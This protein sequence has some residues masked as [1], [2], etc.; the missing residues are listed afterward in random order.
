MHSRRPAVLVLG[1]FCAALTLGSQ[2]TLASTASVESP[3][4]LFVG[5]DGATWKVIGPL[6]E[7]GDLP[8]LARLIKEGAYASS[9]DTLK[10]GT[11]SPLI[12]T[13]IV[14]GRTPKDH[15]IESFVTVLPNGTKIPVTSSSRKARAI[16]ELASQNDLTVGVVGY[17]ASWPA[18]PV[19]GYVI[20]DHANTAFSE[21]MFKDGRLWTEDPARLRSFDRDFYPREIAPILA[22]RWISREDF[23]YENLQLRGQ[24]TDRQMAELKSTDWN[25]FSD[26]Y[27]LLKTMYRVDYPL[28]LIS[29]DLM[30]EKPT[31]L[32]IVY[33]HGPDP[34]QHFA[35][36]LVEPEAYA[37]P[38]P[39]LERDRGLVEGV[40]RAFDSM[41]GELVAATSEDTWVIVASDHGA[42]P[43]P[44]ATGSPRRGRSGEHSYSAKGVLFMRGPKIKPGYRLVGATPYDLMPTL[45][46]LLGLPLSDELEGRVLTEAFDASFV[47]NRPVERVPSYGPRE[48]TSPESSPADDLMLDLLRGLGYIGE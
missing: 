6:I 12:W 46:W 38:N 15:G 32:Q 47:K 20:S 19:N 26:Y 23:S 17:W 33:F 8:T 24:F 42:E 21:F 45:M 22:K 36:D 11:A 27:S 44:R 18:E 3:K 4:V 28:F 31:D 34:V 25:L 10:E 7:Q 5:I 41:L 40:Y 13:T 37:V 2:P 16:W 9:F 39:N 29:K 14:T 43:S 35:W 30:V 1:A 48:T